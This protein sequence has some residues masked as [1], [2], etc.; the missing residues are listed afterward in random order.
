MQGEARS[1]VRHGTAHILSAV[2]KDTSGPARGLH[3]ELLT[4][5]KINV[6]P[7]HR[8]TNVTVKG[9]LR[10]ALTA[11]V[12]CRSAPV[13]AVE[14][15][16][17]CRV[18]Y[19]LVSLLNCVLIGRLTV[20]C[21]P[22]GLFADIRRSCSITHRLN[23]FVMPSRIGAKRSARHRSWGNPSGYWLCSEFLA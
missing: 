3:S 1:C 7:C 15:C 16:A 22:S 14:R 8:N 12:A 23:H 9:Q 2:Q 13:P 20:G 18:F 4:F 10:A 19:A 11:S 6:D 17:Q 5:L 21:R